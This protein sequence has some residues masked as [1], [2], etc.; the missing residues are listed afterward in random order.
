MPR[1]L[2]LLCLSGLF[3]REQFRYLVGGIEAE[4]SPFVRCGLCA[5]A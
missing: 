3:R 1:R 2:A 5:E 4:A